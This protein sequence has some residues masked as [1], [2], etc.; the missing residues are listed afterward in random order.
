MFCK[1][2]PKKDTC[3]KLCKELENY[4]NSNKSDKELLDIDRLYSDRWIRSK[5][6]PYD[7]NMFEEMLPIEAIE[8]VR[9]KEIRELGE[10]R[11]DTV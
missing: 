5:E 10:G 2:C 4:L 9:G 8:R 11:D 1:D 6:I 3:T 7:P